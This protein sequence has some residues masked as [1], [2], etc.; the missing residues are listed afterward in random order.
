[1]VFFVWKVTL[2][3]KYYPKMNENNV[4][5]FHSIEFFSRCLNVNFSD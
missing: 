2:E 4:L 1:M 3:R 5:K